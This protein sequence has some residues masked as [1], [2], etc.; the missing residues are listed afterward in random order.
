MLSRFGS[1][2]ELV[3]NGSLGLKDNVFI[4]CGGVNMWRPNL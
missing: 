2:C 4:K 3:A 1:N